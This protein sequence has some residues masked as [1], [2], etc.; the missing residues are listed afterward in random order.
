MSVVWPFFNASSNAT[1]NKI[2][3]EIELDQ[4]QMLE[5]SSSVATATQNNLST[6][7]SNSNSNS[8]W[9]SNN[10]ISSQQSKKQQQQQSGKSS[11]SINISLFNK[12]IDQPN[13]IDEINISKN[14][15]LIRYIS[16]VEV[17]DILINYSLISLEISMLPNL[18]T[19]QGLN[20]SNDIFEGENNV[21]QEDEHLNPHHQLNLPPVGGKN[22][23]E[24]EELDK[25]ERALKR[26]IVASETLILF[27]GA[28]VQ[29]L[30]THST[31]DQ[32]LLTKLWRGILNR[33]VEDFF[34]QIHKP[35]QDLSDDES[36]INVEQQQQLQQQQQQIDL[37][38]PSN[39]KEAH[40]LTI[41]NNFLKLIDSIATISMQSLMNFI[42]FE[43]TQIDQT[44]LL[45]IQFIKFIPFSQTICDLLVRLISTDKPYNS[46]GLIEILLDQ[47]LIFRLLNIVKT[48]YLDHK[49]QDN[50]CNL[51]NGI[52]GISSNV[53]FW[54]DPSLNPNNVNEMG[55]PLD[56]DQITRNAANNP[57]IGPNDLTRQLVSKRCILEMLDVLINYGNYGLVTVVSVVIEVIRKNN[58]D[59][60]EFDWIGFVEDEDNENDHDNENEIDEDVAVS[61]ETE[62]QVGDVTK[63]LPNSRDPI[64]LGPMLKLFSLHL[65][66]IT[67]NYLTEKYY[68]LKSS[69]IPEL[70]SSIGSIIE[71][72][73]YER[74][75]VMELIA[76]LLHCS[77][78]ILMNK[79]SKLDWLMYKRDLWRDIKK[80]E[81]LVMDALND[82]IN[83][84]ITSDVISKSIG[85]LSLNEDVTSIKDEDEDK[86]KEFVK[87]PIDLSIGNFFKLQLLET[88]AIPLIILKLVQFPWNNFMH[89][90]VF[91]LV[92]QIFNGRLANWDE[93]Q[94]SNQE[95]TKYDD[96]LSLNKILIWSLFGD[97]D[98]YTINSTSSYQ[99][100]S[101]DNDDNDDDEY[102]GFFNLPNFILFCFKHSD[103][104]ESENLFKL[105]Y[106]G[107]LTL[108][109][110]EIHKFQTYVENFG[111]TRTDQT[112]E[113][114]EDENDL[115]CSYY[116][117]TSY[118]IFNSLYDKLFES[119]NFAKWGVFVNGKLKEINEMHNKVLGNPNELSDAD[120]KEEGDDLKS[121]PMVKN[122]NDVIVLDNGDSEEFHRSNEGE[123]EDDLQVIEGGDPEEEEE[124]GLGVEDEDDNYY[125]GGDLIP[126]K[127]TNSVLTDNENDVEIE[128][129]EGDEEDVGVE[130]VSDTGRGRRK[131]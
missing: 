51:L 92:Q 49:V 10:L 27:S 108:I 47:E 37:T 69:T 46:N 76:E 8:N 114:L 102:P 16:Q 38:N 53:G 31:T 42:R 103:E 2:L 7:S 99:C 14:Q 28:I 98:N 118:F 32:Y 23:D 36:D 113:I 100:S 91:D 30:S 107:H 105:G 40:N 13:F 125:D 106:M 3:A 43:Q 81:S 131:D 127:K 78:M 77:N 63:N 54:D 93:D 4:Q 26:S 55:E 29:S 50:L 79:S 48:N 66:E 74:F 72:L 17:L 117:K 121:Q 119:E 87:L 83:D 130:E 97:F 61:G 6:N 126:M 104:Y 33:E 11:P 109:A 73:G 57:N 120:I 84:E 22:D 35:N 95:E 110:E 90:V 45:T 15:K 75:K 80:T 68:S 62:V 101:D 12:L 82:S 85:K 65:K 21:S 64:Y 5:K 60:D 123:D 58:S 96:N 70:K 44:D 89:N 94:A 52:V 25:L 1:I 128:Q 116:S 20:L 67:T 115:S 39:Y 88:H 112:F 59:Y 111:S 129:K 18:E 56:M 122:K 34:P 86:E 9:D 41:F 24:T 71:P 124:V 19:I